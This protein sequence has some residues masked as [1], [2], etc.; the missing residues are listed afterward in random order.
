MKRQPTTIGLCQ[1]L[2]WRDQ[3][4]QEAIAWHESTGSL[5]SA[6]A[7]AY[8]AGYTEGYRDAIAALKLHAGL[9]VDK[10]R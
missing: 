2:R 4:L 8:R 7:P 10:D 6:N 3:T 5:T 9:D 1:T